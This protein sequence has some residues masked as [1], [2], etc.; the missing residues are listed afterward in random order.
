MSDGEI[1]VAVSEARMRGKRLAA[2][3]RSCHSIKQCVRHGY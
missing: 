1:A 2:H 3:A